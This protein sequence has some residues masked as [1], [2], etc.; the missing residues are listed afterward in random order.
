MLNGLEIDME[1]K[2]LYIS[3]ENVFTFK[4]EQ[5]ELHFLAMKSGETGKLVEKLVEKLMPPP[6]DDIT[7]S[8]KDIKYQLI[9][10]EMN[11]AQI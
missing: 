6:Q 2:E 5:Y 11:N 1:I 3:P 9:I 10:K 7:V 4:D 8:L